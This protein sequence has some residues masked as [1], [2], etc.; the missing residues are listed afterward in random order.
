M[1]SSPCAPLFN[2]PRREQTLPAHALKLVGLFLL[3]AGTLPAQSVEN[4]RRPEPAHNRLH[5]N[6]TYFGQDIFVGPNQQ[7]HNATC[8]FCSV[9]VD[10]KLS[11]SAF[12][13]FGNIT[14]TGEVAGSTASI[15]GNTVVDSQA[16]IAGAATVIGGNAVYETDESLS[17]NAYVLGGHISNFAGRGSDHRRLSLSP[18]ISAALAVVAFI[19]LGILLF[20]FSARQSP[21]P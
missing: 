10:G 7:I 6:R 19:L 8:L 11:G 15:G 4:Q 18:V 13:L 1:R 9:Q 14:V 17:G 20:R 16:R 21:R 12:V 3:L 2:P 5:A